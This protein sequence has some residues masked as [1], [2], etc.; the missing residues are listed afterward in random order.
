VSAALNI[1]IRIW[2]VGC[3]QYP[4]ACVLLPLKS[5]TYPPPLALLTW[6]IFPVPSRQVRI[7]RHVSLIKGW[8]LP[9]LHVLRTCDDPIEALLVEAPAW[10]AFLHSV[11]REI[12]PPP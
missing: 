9:F 3:V 5:Y 1:D 2:G 7:R 12:S 8:C 4:L 10:F 11:D 6:Q